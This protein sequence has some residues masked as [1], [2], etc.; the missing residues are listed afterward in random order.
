MAQV[1]AERGPRNLELQIA[2]R[3]DAAGAHVLGKRTHRVA[4]A[5]DLCG[6]PLP[7]LTLRTPVDE[8]RLGRPRQHVDEPGGDGKAARVDAERRRPTVEVPDRDDPIVTDTYVG[9]RQARRTAYNG[10]AGMM[11]L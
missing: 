6:H 3:G 5:E 4:F 1:V 2:L 10:S 11:T 7:Y 9:A 8:K